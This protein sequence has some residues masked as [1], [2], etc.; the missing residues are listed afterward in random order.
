MHSLQGEFYILLNLDWI[1]SVWLI[2][3]IYIDM[4]LIWKR[5]VAS[6][7]CVPKT[8][9]YSF[10][11]YYD[12]YVVLTIT[13][14]ERAINVVSVCMNIDSYHFLFF[15]LARP[16]DEDPGC[17]SGRLYFCVYRSG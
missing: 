8:V 1:I 14:T 7:L 6:C 15:D 5:I 3:Y 9:M 2:L 17:S 16:H 13:M 12:A 4:S 10:M 11:N